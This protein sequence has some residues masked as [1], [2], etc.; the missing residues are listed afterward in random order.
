MY[1][2][3]MFLVLGTDY[4]VETWKIAGVNSVRLVPEIVSDV[5]SLGPC[6]SH[7]VSD[8]CSSL[9]FGRILSPC[10]RPQSS[11]PWQSQGG[12]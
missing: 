1:V 9:G 6:I 4:S 11:V 8:L 5:L 3:V 12:S 7:S 10:T 2:D